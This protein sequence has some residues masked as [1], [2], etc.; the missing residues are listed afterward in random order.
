[1]EVSKGPRSRLA[2]R[3]QHLTLPLN[4]Q[5]FPEQGLEIPGRW[6]GLPQ[7]RQELAFTSRTDLAY[8]LSHCRRNVIPSQH[9]WT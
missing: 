9:S 1:M 5:K 8:S 6:H 2:L 4:P 7:R 3:G